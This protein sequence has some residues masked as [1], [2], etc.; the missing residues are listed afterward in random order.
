MALGQRRVIGPEHE[1]DVREQ[2]AAVQPNASYSSTC[3]GV[4]EM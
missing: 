1:R 2:P 4:L 3:R